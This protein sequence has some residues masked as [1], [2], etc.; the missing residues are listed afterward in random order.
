VDWDA[1]WVAGV[2]S[3][4]RAR[5]VRLPSREVDPDEGKIALT[6]DVAARLAQSEAEAEAPG[7]EE[8]DSRIA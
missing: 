8:R 4:R 6:A 3:G 5:V 7:D 2:G 1:T